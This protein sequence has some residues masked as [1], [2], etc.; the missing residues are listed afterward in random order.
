[1]EE[2]MCHYPLVLKITKFLFLSIMTVSLYADWE[3]FT[4]DAASGYKKP[5]CAL[6][7]VK[8]TFKA[9]IRKQGRDLI[10]Y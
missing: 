4:P 5:M 9:Y 6:D 10:N 1:M 8:S 2:D 3:E 7:G